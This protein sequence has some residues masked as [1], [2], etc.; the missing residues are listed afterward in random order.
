MEKSPLRTVSFWAAISLVVLTVFL[1]SLVYFRYV[2]LHVM[3]VPFYVHHWMSIA[4]TLF[5]ALFTP[6]YS[7]LKRH[8]PTHYNA[9]V[10]AHVFGSLISVMLISIHFTQQVSR[11]AQSYPNLAT[12]V[13]LYA[14]M[15][16][17]VF[18]GF[19]LRFHFAR[20]IHKVW[21][22]L[23][24]SFALSFYLIIVVHIL[25]GLQFI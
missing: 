12:G 6:A 19:L 18:T 1:M 10:N 5:I 11:P 13:V 7:Y 15:I 2:H 22:F 23:H 8:N 20:S 3:V 4:G 9:I 21:R 16:I 24:T 25:H 14:V 17:F